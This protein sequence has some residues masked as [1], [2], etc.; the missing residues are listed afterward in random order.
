[1]IKIYVHKEA[2]NAV[3]PTIAYNGLSAA[4]DLTCT[5]TTTIPSKGSAVVP[6]GLNLIIPEDTPNYYMTIHLRSSMGFKKKLVPHQGIIDAG[7]T[8]NIAVLIHN[9]SDEDV[10]IAE[11]DR[12]AQILVHE[13]PAFELVELNDELYES[14]KSNQERGDGGFGSSGK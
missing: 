11:G 5:K 13:K 1:M 8:G 3:V 12:Y 2:K 6:N 10:T 14:L 4:F 9:L 7:Y